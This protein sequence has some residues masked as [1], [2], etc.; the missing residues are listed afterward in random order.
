MQCDP[1]ARGRKNF[2]CCRLFLIVLFFLKLPCKYWKWD[3]LSN[4]YVPVSCDPL[5]QALRGGAEG[6]LQ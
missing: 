1:A 2:T 4:R 3:I 6:F 5:A